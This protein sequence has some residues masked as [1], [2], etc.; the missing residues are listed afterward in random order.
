MTVPS[1][2]RTLFLLAGY[3]DKT[4]L[5]HSPAGSEGDGVYAVVLDPAGEGVHLR[6][7]SS[8]KLESNPTVILR[9]HTLDIVY[10]VTEVINTMSE[11][12]MARINR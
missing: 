12:I 2:P 6:L 8:S 10:M 3:T 1:Y 9:H 7:L 4:S 5:A 11:L